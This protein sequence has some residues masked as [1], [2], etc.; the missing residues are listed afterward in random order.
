MCEAKSSHLANTILWRIRSYKLADSLVWICSTEKWDFMTYYIV[1]H[2]ILWCWLL[3]V[4]HIPGLPWCIDAA[5]RL[6]MTRLSGLCHI[7]HKSQNAPL[8]YPIMLHSEQ[9]SGIC[10]IG[11]FKLIRV[12][13]EFKP[14]TIPFLIMSVMSSSRWYQYPTINKN[15]NICS[16]INKCELLCRMMSWQGNVF[17]VIVP[18]MMTSSNGNIFRVT[19]PLCGEFTGTGEFP[20]QR[21]V[22]RSFDVFSDL[23]LNKQ[24]SKQPWDW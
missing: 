10:E 15:G 5:S 22:T 19:G 13:S 12:M 20:T 16:S 1:P 17:L 14:A 3:R 4:G 21:P 8:P 24:L 2:S 18:F 9:N 23:R 6:R 11:L 7:I